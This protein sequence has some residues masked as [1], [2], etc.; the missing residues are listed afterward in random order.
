MRRA[1]T[2]A[3]LV[4][5]RGRVSCAWALAVGLSLALLLVLAAQ[6][7]VATGAKTG[8]SAPPA[9]P[10]ARVES[11]AAAHP[12]QSRV[13]SGRPALRTSA[14]CL[15][16]VAVRVRNGTAGALAPAPLHYGPLLR[17]PP[18]SLS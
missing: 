15:A 10:A 3:N 9:A 5:V 14:F 16:F 13:D 17:R 1:G 7:A 8:M 6:P 11:A 12:L 4:L 18:P 2:S